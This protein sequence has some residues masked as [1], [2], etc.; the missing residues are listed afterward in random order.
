M[1]LY[2]KSRQAVTVLAAVMAVV[3]ALS[4]L[5]SAQWRR[6]PQQ[7]RKT[8]RAVA[9]LETYADGQ[10]RLIPVSFFYQRHYYDAAL[11]RAAPVPFTLSTETVYEVEQ[12]GKALGTFTVLSA[13]RQANQDE[14]AWFASGRYRVAPDPATLARKRAAALVV[15][16]DPT[17][18]VLHRRAGSEGDRPPGHTAAAK[19][20]TPNAPSD[21]DRPTLHRSPGSA[22]DAP[23]TQPA[24]PSAAQ[25]ATQTTPA[26]ATETQASP[27]QD[28]DRPVLHRHDDAGD[29]KTAA[30]ATTPAAS[31]TAP[32][33]TSPASASKAEGGAS[34]DAAT[35]D[36]DT[37]HPILRRGKP[38]EEQS[39]SDLPE[40]NPALVP[41]VNPGTGEAGV[42]APEPMARQVAVSDAGTSD[43]QDV[44]FACR[45]EQ[46][47]QMEAQAR[48]LAEAELR[49]A[50]SMRGLLLPEAVKADAAT[51]E[52][53][54]TG[55]A[56]A[57]A[58]RTKTPAGSQ[59]KASAPSSPSASTLAATPAALP[60]DDEQFVPY[61]LDYD[62]YATVVF[63]GRYRAGAENRSWVVTVI[64]RQDGD[65]LVKL[66]SA[67]SDPRELDL[68]PEVRLVD[69]VDPDGYGRY[70]LLFR[71]Q[72]RDGVK[73]LLGRVSGYE[74]ETLFETSER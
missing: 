65:K 56:K 68:Y 57:A 52:T 70:A 69:A 5:A 49:K 10:R 34:A 37:D 27:E 67:V 15:V 48:Q 47:L 36:E 21:S 23:Q 74:L 24:N 43:P 53:A 39:G 38:R 16:D 51:A 40:F 30:S 60:F 61:D 12:F 6:A 29:Q 50:A 41:A 19:N 13:L 28:A 20:S 58:V 71:K 2:R 35:S 59:T 4:P 55:A 63:S 14:A 46:R 17:R 64:A 73:W 33:P 9:V 8:P 1:Y 45:P 62:D 11:Y 26:Q 22:G 66:Y 7:E 42:R 25:T 32:T 3:A 72:G 44:T 31:A 54:K 18:P